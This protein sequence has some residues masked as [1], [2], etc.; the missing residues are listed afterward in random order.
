MKST[1]RFSIKRKMVIIF[2][3]LITASF[4]L[5]SFAAMRRARNAI[6]EKVESH[7]VDKAKDTAALI[8]SKLATLMQFL[9]DIVEYPVIKDP[10][11]PLEEKDQYVRDTVAFHSD[12]EFIDFC[13]ANGIWYTDEGQ[14]IDI[15]D[16]EWFKQAKMGKIFITEPFVSRKNKNLLHL[17]LSV[18]IFSRENKMIGALIGS[19]K[20]ESFTGLIN[21]IVVGETGDCYIVG[22]TGTVIAHKDKTL[23]ES[24]YNVP[25]EA[26]KDPHL[27][28]LGFY[29]E[30]LLNTE[31]PVLGYYEYHN[32][33]F[34][35]CAAT[36][37]SKQWNVIVRAPIKEFLGAIDTMRNN[38]LIVVVIMLTIILLIVFFTAVQI[39]KPINITVDALKDIAHGGGDLTVR[40]PVRGHDETTELSSYFNQTIEKIGASIREVSDNSERMQGI[41]E[42]LSANMSET[43]SAIHQISTNIEGVKE[44]TISQ[45]SS[46][47]ETAS[48]MEEIIRTIQNLNSSIE[49]QAESVS[50]SSS[51]VEQMVAN[52]ASITENLSKAAGAIRELSHATNDGKATVMNSNGI[53]QKIAEESG[54]LIE[55]S[56]VIQ[57]IASQT[58]LLA[59]NAAIE[60]AHAGEAGKGFAV[61]ADEIRKLAEE[62]STQGKTITATL[63]T[64]GSEI[65]TL[66][67]S[68]KIVDEKFNI[69]FTLSEQVRHTSE[70]LTQAMREQELGSREVLTAMQNINAVTQEVKNGSAEML[71]GGEQI[72]EEMHKLDELTST[73][74]DSMN[75]MSAS[76]VQINNAVT[77]VSTITQKNRDA[78][79][80][81]NT[82]VKKFKI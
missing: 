65:E 36:M 69:I 4:I 40:L 51:A 23:V 10:T 55:A 2:G 49:N 77:E 21:D 68:S 43:A 30:Q 44:Q 34:I 8:D 11:V 12:F 59:M 50:Q 39:A 80:A 29:V 82:E 15:S 78:I 46:V 26:K 5:L 75:E 24:A 47:T 48:T 79:G 14:R 63:K 73:I 33:H 70:Q 60:A 20:S 58:N 74:S 19:L 1:V 67:D 18:P 37:K 16:R 31:E 41:G 25:E 3:S 64:L 61:V 81:L 22:L 76:A 17:V 52:I 56:N 7:L 28:E 45:A 13:D 38:F 6:I 27:L 32:T 53:T 42:E 35:A 62:S 66:A 9:K 57:N 71:V 54:G 72:A